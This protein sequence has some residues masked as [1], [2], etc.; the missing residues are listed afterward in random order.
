MTKENKK[1]GENWHKAMKENLE[2]R[3][4]NMKNN[5]RSKI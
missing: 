1:K 5:D 4:R 2:K 3:R